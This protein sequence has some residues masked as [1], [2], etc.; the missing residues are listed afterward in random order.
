MENIGTSAA[1]KNNTE[2]FDR[3][4]ITYSKRG[5]EFVDAYI[6]TEVIHLIETETMNFY[7]LKIINNNPEERTNAFYN[8]VFAED[9]DSGEVTSCI[10]QYSPELSWLFDKSEGYKGEIVKYDNQ[11]I[12]IEEAMSG[13]PIINGQA[14]RIITCPFATQSWYCPNGHDSPDDLDGN[15]GGNWEYVI[16][17]VPCYDTGGG[18]G[19]GEGGTGGGGSPNPTH[20]VILEICNDYVPA[21][22]SG[23]SEDCEEQYADYFT[24]Y[25]CDDYVDFALINFINGWVPNNQAAAT[26][27]ANYLTN[28]YSE[29]DEDN[30]AEV[31]FEEQLVLDP[32]LTTCVKDI[33]TDL[34]DK[35]INLP[36]IPELPIDLNL[37]SIILDLFDNSSNHNYI[38]K[39]GA[40]GSNL[41]AQTTPSGVGLNFT[42][43][44]TLNTSFVT[45]AT[46]LA[47]ARTIIHESLHAYFEFLYQDLPFSSLSTKLR[48]HLSVKGVTSN[49][50]Q[51]LLMVQFVEAMAYSLQNWDN[52]SLGSLDYYNYLAWS[53]DMLTTPDFALL[54]QTFQ[55]NVINANIAEGQAGV[56]NGSTS[57]AKGNNNCQ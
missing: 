29:N 39:M 45:N 54:P 38:L 23:N 49:S 10:L 13:D 18:G 19:G 16:I 30:C 42:Y 36:I 48:H 40:L 26:E 52:N 14:N 2:Y 53:G 27:L 20:T 22:G 6:D 33:I 9:F 46:D 51:H 1:F 25:I 43:T 3:N 15:C 47:I 34:K 57:N 12:S 44:T 8:L 50:A 17:D 28:N 37:S 35:S 41:N 24:P 56:G 32:S 5:G 11:L 21:G 55:T 31:D 7:T 4:K